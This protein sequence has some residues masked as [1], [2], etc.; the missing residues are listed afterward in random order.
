[1]KD[2]F[3][4]RELDVWFVRSDEVR[5]RGTL[6]RYA[7][8]MAP[9]ERA[10]HDRFRFEKDRHLFLVTRGTIRSLVAAYLGVDAAS[11]VF[12]ADRH[13]KPSLIH[14]G[15]TGFCFNLSHTPGAVACAIA[16]EPEIGVD[17]ERVDRRV[18]PDL[19]RRF[20]STEEAG[21]LGALPE[22]AQAVRFYEYWTLKEA[23]IKARGLGLALPL[24]GFTM[25]VDDAGPPRIRFAPSI[26]D[27]AAS[28]QFAH[29]MSTPAHRLAVAARRRAGDWRISLREFIPTPT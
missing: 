12:E 10:R 7:A 27:D 25:L 11:C 20:F 29:F 3:V 6:E 8:M 16:P 1:M 13:G 14:P 4:L 26:P 5:D 19:P 24:D 22:P 28:W 17:V 15:G 2:S 23:Y 9:D 21:T 18:S